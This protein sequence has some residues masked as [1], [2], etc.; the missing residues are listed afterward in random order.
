MNKTTLT[1][2]FTQFFSPLT[3]LWKAI[4]TFCKTHLGM[5]VLIILV[6]IVLFK[7]MWWYYHHKYTRYYDWWYYH[8]DMTPRRWYHVIPTRTYDDIFSRTER[9]INEQKR[10]MEDRMNQ[11]IKNTSQ[12]INNDTT[13]GIQQSISRISSINGESQWYTLNVSN[14]TINWSIIWSVSEN[15]IQWLQNNNIILDNN[16][17]SAPYSPELFQ[18]LTTLFENN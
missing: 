14:N 6:L 5:V 10:I 1:Q 9:Y 18:T 16:N 7:L 13:T 15:I 3:P 12:V 2:H 17:F 8:R 4:V 11:A